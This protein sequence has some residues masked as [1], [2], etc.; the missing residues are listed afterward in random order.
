MSLLL[1]EVSWPLVVLAV[2]VAAFVVT[3]PMYRRLARQANLAAA[4]GD[5]ATSLAATIRLRNSWLPVTLLERLLNPGHFEVLIAVRLVQLGHLQDALTWC[6]HGL[7]IARRPKTK[8]CLN[9]V[10]AT[11]WSVIGDAEKCEQHLSVLAD[12]LH[13]HPMSEIEWAPSA[14]ICENNLGR[15]DAAWQI[16]R[17]E[18][19]RRGGQV[20]PRWLIATLMVLKNLGRHAEVLRLAEWPLNQGSLKPSVRLPEGQDAEAA[21]G[22]DRARASHRSTMLGIS[23]VYAAWSAQKTDQW[24]LGERYLAALESAGQTG[25][26]MIAQII[27]IRAIDQAHNGDRAAV[28]SAQEAI[29]ELAQKHPD[30]R[31][32]WPDAGLLL[33]ESWQILGEHERAMA[34]LSGV[35]SALL[36][37]VDRSHLAAT[38]A[39][40]LEALGQTAQA[41][42]K[43]EEA[44]H[45][46]PLAYWNQPEDVSEKAADSLGRPEADLVPES[47]TIE[48]A[49]EPPTD[50]PIERI[51]SPLASVAWI[52]AVFALLPVI[53][54]LAALPLLLIGIALLARRRTLPHDRR[55]G[56]AATLISLFSLACAGLVVG[57]YVHAWLRTP[58]PVRSRAAGGGMESS[59]G[60]EDLEWSDQTSATTSSAPSPIEPEDRLPAEPDS[61]AG[62]QDQER[63]RL[64]SPDEMLSRKPPFWYHILSLAV[65]IF[66]VIFHEVAHAVAACWSGDPT[67]RDQGRFSLHPRRHIDPLGSIIVPVIMSLMPGDVI[68]GWARPVPVRPQRFRHYR[69]A[70]VGVS[71]A[72]VSLNLMLALWAT[73]V[74]I[75]ILTVLRWLHPEVVEP[76]ALFAINVP[77][78]LP[79]VPAGTVWMLG[80]EICRV[81]ILVNVLLANFNLLPLPPLDGFGVIRGLTPG[82]LGGVL[83]K[84]SGM[85][86]ILLLVLLLTRA[87]DVLLLPGV[88]L[89]AGLLLGSAVGAHW[90]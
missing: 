28:I 73:N 82:F 34:L 16:A 47:V 74:L 63:Q 75:A 85:G 57:N 58:G 17:E 37:P 71:L 4:Q 61:S 11:I 5:Y 10:A 79:D 31:T 83:N 23:L 35:D 54:S 20:S 84:I 53:G 27:G 7:R 55:V 68:I 49:V 88:Y 62:D 69:R 36:P 38:M 26:A 40:S 12:I 22:A 65:I 8:A 67:A 32:I 33:A 89:V 19:R 1:A 72:G 48:A 78:R 6:H 9:D 60:D 81:A 51:A 87:L 29:E 2:I 25:P 18:S 13:K 66:S 41:E 59:R 52:L 45:L 86:M 64:A 15:L 70:T 30:N 24:A 44:R 77:I 21:L 3:W 90:R 43:R 39:R 42:A 14:S 46:A 50:Q 80:I 76:R 56:L